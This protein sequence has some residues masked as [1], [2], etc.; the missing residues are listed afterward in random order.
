MKNIFRMCFRSCY[1]P[2]NFQKHYRSRWTN[3]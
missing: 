3:L 2:I 1:H